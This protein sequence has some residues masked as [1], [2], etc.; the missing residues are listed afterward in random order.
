[1]ELKWTLSARS[2]AN[3]SIVEHGRNILL[4]DSWGIQSADGLTTALIP[5][6]TGFVSHWMRLSVPWEEGT[7]INTVLYWEYCR[8]IC[9]NSIKI[10]I[11][12]CN[13]VDWKFLTFVW[14]FKL[15]LRGLWPFLFFAASAPT[16]AASADA[17]ADAAAT[18]TVT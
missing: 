14:L 1:M 12:I 9:F 16:S 15:F 4:W 5:P 10:K 8:T 2:R 17:T 18:V 11:K 6:Q 13:L 7:Q 3:N